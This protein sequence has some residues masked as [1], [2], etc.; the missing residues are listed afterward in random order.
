M[1]IGFCGMQEWNVIAET[2]KGDNV[3]ALD[4]AFIIFDR[5]LRQYETHL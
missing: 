5:L 2:R 4:V 3:C 1:M